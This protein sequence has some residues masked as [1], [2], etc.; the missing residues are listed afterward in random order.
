MK[1]LFDKFLI[2]IAVI[3]LSAFIL[4]YKS[5]FMWSHLLLSAYTCNQFCKFSLI[6]HLTQN[7]H[8][9]FNSLYVIY[10]SKMIILSGIFCMSIIC[11]Y[12]VTS[13]VLRVGN[14][15]WSNF[16]SLFYT[17]WTHWAKNAKFTKK[18]NAGILMTKFRTKACLKNLK[19]K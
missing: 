11:T 5:C 18:K 6:K 14:N 15:C 9:R 3:T 19:S 1:S 10:C 2:T 12:N 16:E 8:Y 17:P 7:R 4:S 13:N